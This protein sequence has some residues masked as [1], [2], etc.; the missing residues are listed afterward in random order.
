MYHLLYWW[1]SEIC[2]ISSAPNR[3]I[4]L[5][6]LVLW[7]PKMALELYPNGQAQATST[8]ARHAMSIT[9]NIIHTTCIKAWCLPELVFSNQAPNVAAGP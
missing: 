8:L 1:Q 9:P 5:L 6:H 7:L 3:T 4:S 2:Q